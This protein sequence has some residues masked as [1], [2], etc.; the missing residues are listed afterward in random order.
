MSDGVEKS[1]GVS[2][3]LSLGRLLL[4]AGMFGAGVLALVYG[5]FDLQWQR[6]DF[7]SPPLAYANGAILVAASIALLAP[8]FP[9]LGGYALAALMLVW[10]AVFNIPRVVAGVEAAWLAV[11]EPLAVGLGAYLVTQPGELAKRIVRL[12]FGAC[13]VTFGAAHFLYL[14]F[15]AGMIP[16]FI[17][18]HLF[19]AAFTGAGHVAAGLSIA[20]GILARFGA[21]LLGLMYTLFVV[22]LHV[23][24]VMADPMSRVEWTMLCHATALSG[25]AWLIASTFLAPRR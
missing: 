10:V 17:P 25:A 4:S 23:P 24:R 12:L 13:C 1:D 18:A 3:T 16:A 8:R 11:A 15:T 6:G 21:P 9:K 19:F 20:S 14:D 7:H 2:P 5:D 22:L